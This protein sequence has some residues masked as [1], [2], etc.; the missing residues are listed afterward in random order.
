MVR[1]IATQHLRQLLV[2]L[3][4]ILEDHTAAGDA[5]PAAPLRS[6]EGCL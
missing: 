4:K 1:H 3:K 2:S 6:K 5:K